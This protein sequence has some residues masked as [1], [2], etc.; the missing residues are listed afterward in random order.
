MK[1]PYGLSRKQTFANVVAILIAALVF[2]LV[3]GL[4]LLWAKGAW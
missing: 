4:F 1:K 2:T 3:L